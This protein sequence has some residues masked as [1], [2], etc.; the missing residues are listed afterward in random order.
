MMMA[1]HFPKFANIIIVAAVVLSM[2]IISLLLSAKK[3][4]PLLP[5]LFI[6]DARLNHNR[7]RLQLNVDGFI[8]PKTVDLRPAIE[9]RQE[10]SQELIL[11]NVLFIGT[12]KAG[13]TSIFKWLFSAGVCAARR[14]DDDMSPLKETSFFL[15]NIRPA[16]EVQQ[17]AELFQHCT[18]YDYIVDADPSHIVHPGGVYEFYQRAGYDALS[19]L[20]I[21]V[22]LREP[23]SRELS[24]YNHHVA[25]VLAGEEKSNNPQNWSWCNHVVRRGE[26]LSFEEYANSRLKKWLSE[27]PNRISLSIYADYLKEWM[28]LFH[29]DQ[30]LVLSYD[31]IMEDSSMVQWRIRQFLGGE[32]PGE[33][34]H[35]NHR[36]YEGK[37]ERASLEARRALEPF[38]YEKNSELYRL[39]DENPGPWMEQRPFRRFR[40]FG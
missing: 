20:K 3:I 30:I 22:S 29:R 5:K 31:E 19:R 9:R 10:V 6:S 1:S 18:S 11:P 14:S 7:R 17:Y 28:S 16:G 35:S 27:Y 33:L 39:L 34:P 32:F 15:P 21:I 36:A 37:V 4:T 38:F 24:L 25:C 13:S 26:L 8:D 40:D 23:V 2:A 12:Q